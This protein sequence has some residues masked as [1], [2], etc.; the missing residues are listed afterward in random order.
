MTDR[1]VTKLLLVRH[2]ESQVTVKGILG[3][4]KTDTGL[5]PLG[6]LQAEALSDRW[7]GGGEPAVDALY[8]STLPRAIETA[9]ILGPQLGNLDLQLDEDL[10]EHRP[11]EAD[12]MRFDDL[13][14]R[15]GPID[16][17]TRPHRP[18]A[19][20]AESAAQFYHRASRGLDR[21]VSQNAGKCVVVACHGGVIDI[22]FRYFLDLPRNGT[23]DLHTLN[24]SI[25]EFR[26]DDSGPQRGRWRLQRYN[27]HAHLAGLP[28]ETPRS[29]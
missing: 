3:G 28:P 1:R 11:G 20:G 5:S 16:F 10:V 24:T 21:V 19:P 25:T 23:F 18:F 22:A 6:K 8:S 29:E 12:G 9:E 13:E 27:D 7:S 15:Y 2:G 4:E 14:A 17:R 26:V